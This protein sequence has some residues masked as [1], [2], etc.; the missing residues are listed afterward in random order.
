[1][2]S[3]LVGK[4]VR[5][6]GWRH[7]L[8]L[9]ILVLIVGAVGWI[10][11]LTRS[12]QVARF[13]G[14]LLGGLTGSQVHIESA[15]FGLN[16]QITLSGIE[17][18][19]PDPSLADRRIFE[20][21]QVLIHHSFLHLIRGRFHARELIVINPTLFLTEDLTRGRYNLEFLGF[22]HEDQEDSAESETHL[23]DLFLRSGRVQFGQVSE[24]RYEELGAIGIHGKLTGSTG[25][26]QAYSFSLSQDPFDPT[27]AS[28][29]VE[30]ADTI[31]AG[32]ADGS[33]GVGP[34][35][36]G[37]FDL[38]TGLV[39]ADLTH[40][41]LGP[42][43]R[44]TLPNRMRRWW[45]RFSPS[46]AV[47]QARFVFRPDFGVVIEMEIR[48]AEL[49]LPYTESTE[50]PPRMTGVSGR[51]TVDRRGFAITELTGRTKDF[52]C[53]I[54]GRVNGFARDSSLDL[55]I[56]TDTFTIPDDPGYLSVLP[57]D[58]QKMFV[59]FSPS[60]QGRAQ[61]TF[62]RRAAGAA[63]TYQ[64]TLRVINGS[65]TYHRFPYPLEDLNGTFRF[66]DQLVELL[67]MQ[68]RGP[69]GARFSLS[70]AVSPLSPHAAVDLTVHAQDLPID[71][72]LHQ[73]VPPRARVILDMFLDSKA[74]QRL[75]DQGLIRTRDQQHQSLVKLNQLEARRRGERD[76]EARVGLDAQISELV[77]ALAVPAFDLGGTTTATVKIERTYGQGE[78]FRARATVP[79]AGIDVLFRHLP[80]PVRLT[81]GQVEIT[82]DHVIVEAVEGQ[83][84]RGGVGQ[85]QGRIDLLR[86]GTQRL[87]PD[88][89]LVVAD[90]PF[91][92]LLQ[93]S[94]PAGH[95]KTLYDMNLTGRLDATGEIFRQDN[96]QI[97][98]RVDTEL[99][100]GT[101]RPFSRSFQ[102]DQLQGS[103]LLQRGW[104]QIHDLHGRHGP[105]R[106]TLTGTGDWRTEQPEIRL[107]LD[108]ES[109]EIEADLLDVLPSNEPACRRFRQL[110]AQRNLNGA[111]DAQ[112]FYDRSQGRRG[113][114]RV[115][116]RPRQLRFDLR[117]Q[118]VKLTAMTG[119]LLVSSHGINLADCGGSFGTGRFS[120]DG[121]IELDPHFFVD[122]TFD[123][124]AGKV[125]DTTR[126]AM[127]RPVRKLID[128]LQ[129]DGGYQI[130]D[131]RLKYDRPSDGR[132]I[133][134][135][136]DAT[137][138]LE[139]ARALVGVAIEQIYGDL[140]VHAIPAPETNFAHHAQEEDART[141]AGASGGRWPKVD[142]KLNADSVVAARR[143]IGPLTLQI[144][145]DEQTHRLNIERFEGTCYGG[146]VLGKGRVELGP[147]GTYQLGLTMQD[148]ALDPFIR[149]QSY[150][151][152][153][154]K[155]HAA[156]SLAQPTGTLSANLT[157]EGLVANPAS[158]RGRGEL[159]IRNADM[160]DVPLAVATLQ[161][162]NLTLPTSKSFDRAWATYLVENDLVYLDLL[163]I[164]APTIEI[165][166]AGVMDWST[167]GLDLD[168]FTRNPTSPQ[169]GPLSDLLDVFKD[170]LVSIHVTGTLDDPQPRVASFQ[171][172]KRSWS[173]VFSPAKAPQ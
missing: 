61:V 144:T 43:Q 45:D 150:E 139:N 137:V 130:H 71:E 3:H 90:V 36:R 128:K 88:L 173:D 145:S 161:I 27:P 124:Q 29:T 154:G 156:G 23:P 138:H 70:G 111:I 69:T 68:G 80:Y 72:M 77:D 87:A 171:G 166:G 44:F 5:S 86:K 2:A 123:A 75:I 126:A 74:Y 151:S 152:T 163:Q 146:T 134:Y 50:S 84:L 67:E 101:A 113:T 14:D 63:L 12:S 8:G 38:N 148:V 168:M 108:A 42:W 167:L 92:D 25:D 30:P 97:G 41:S 121:R 20:A 164:Q 155:I 39:E 133:D 7:R 37:R 28:D 73:A 98:Y 81:G 135:L 56:E 65:S 49:M 24:G 66:T 64:G 119:N 54:N 52:S 115:D 57:K 17:L 118:R 162:L 91:D 1:M 79:L 85:V 15:R 51:F 158:R 83:G 34:T 136:V 114:Y 165:I 141:E 78:K 99:R 159:E 4:F 103:A 53:V 149:P 109:L 117:D 106:L 157:L 100:S 40:F 6:R 143:V 120:T 62:H 11:Y 122:L 110:C 105:S 18:S 33:K 82:P 21:D 153:Q 48:D 26:R 32:S 35:V 19:S 22:H 107:T 112:L 31:T 147:N 94:L 95:Q 58:L 140:S 170:Q 59:A 93:A 116:I 9:I 16:G 76:H 46:G 129:L 60:G 127:P 169:F 47:P 89:D 125:C 172:I 10:A 104:I 132:E 142:L 96:G 102:I 55:T 131:A 13:A 160:Y